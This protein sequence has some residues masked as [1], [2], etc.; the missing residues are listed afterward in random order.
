METVDNESE[1]GDGIERQ[2]EGERARSKELQGNEPKMRRHERG[3]GG[4][5]HRSIQ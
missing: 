1:R 3:G 5:K 2:R 4:Y